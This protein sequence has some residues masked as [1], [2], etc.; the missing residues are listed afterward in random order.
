MK[1]LGILLFFLMNITVFAQNTVYVGDLSSSTIRN[2]LAN[3]VKK[4]SNTVTVIDTKDFK[5]SKNYL[6]VIFTTL[7]EKDVKIA[8]FITE[9]QKLGK[10]ILIS[11]LKSQKS[12]FLKD[13]SYGA[14]DAY[15]MP[16]QKAAA[17]KE[18]SIIIDV[19]KK[20][21]DQK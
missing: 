12:S 3:I 6:N 13:S 21:I 14:I 16:T 15:T 7:T 9:Q 18:S 2:F 10:V 4:A 17:L 5:P 1:K 11:L 19:L 20:K 8:S